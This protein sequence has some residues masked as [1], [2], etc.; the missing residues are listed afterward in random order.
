MIMCNPQMQ[1]FDVLTLLEMNEILELEHL[2]GHSTGRRP[3]V[4]RRVSLLTIGEQSAVLALVLVV[5]VVV[6]VVQVQS[7]I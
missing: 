7:A 4:S 5:V 1:S 2:K 3:S 6:V